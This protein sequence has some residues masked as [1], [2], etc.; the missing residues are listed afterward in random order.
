MARK[1]HKAEEI[2]DKFRRV[3]AFTAEGRSAAEALRSIGVMEVTYN[4]L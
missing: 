3:E 2:T 1:S 4:R